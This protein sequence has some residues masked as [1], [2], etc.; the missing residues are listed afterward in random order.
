M[1]KETYQLLRKIRRKGE[2]K[3]GLKLNKPILKQMIVNPNSQPLPPARLPNFSSSQKMV[4][5]MI[6]LYIYMY[7][8]IIQYYT[9]IKIKLLKVKQNMVLQFLTASTCI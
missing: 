4:K 2:H 3:H 8:Y 5:Q 7:I 9:C 6:Y 1:I